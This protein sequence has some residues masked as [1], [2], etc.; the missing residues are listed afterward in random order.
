MDLLRGMIKKCGETEEAIKT[1]GLDQII[2][3]ELLIVE[4]SS[5]NS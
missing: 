5:A 3:V 2:G 1:G 4:F